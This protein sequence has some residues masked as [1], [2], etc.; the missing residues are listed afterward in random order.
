MVIL[1]LPDQLENNQKFII[2]L[3]ER[4]AQT[5][6]LISLFYYF[7]AQSAQEKECADSKNSA[8]RVQFHLVSCGKSLWTKPSKGTPSFGRPAREL[9]V[10]SLHMHFRGLHHFIPDRFLNV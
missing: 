6:T 5:P 4:S 9:T 1:F 8:C 7:S 3:F 10:S 2:V